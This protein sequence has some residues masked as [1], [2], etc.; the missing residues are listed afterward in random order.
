MKFIP[1]SKWIPNLKRPLV[2]AGP[3]SAESEEQVVGLAHRLREIEDVRIYRAGIWKPRTRPNAFEGHGEKALPW[4]ARVKKE[5]GLLTA[6][7]VANAQHAE[8]AL[9][10]GID[11][12]WIGARTTVSPF[13]VQEIADATRGSNAIVMI[14]NPVSADL[15]LWIGAFERFSQ[16]GIT[17]LAAIHRGFTTGSESK[18]RNPPLW[19]LPVALKQRFPDLPMICDPSHITGNRDLV[20]R[21]CQK[22]MDVDMDGLMIETHFT[23]DEAWSDAAQQV[24]PDQLASII[25]NLELRTEFSLDRGFEQELDGLRSQIDRIDRDIIEA[26]SLRMN[27]VEKIAQSK[28]KNNITAFQLH[29]MDQMMKN[30]MALGEKLGLEQNYINELYG[31]IHGES[32]KL[33]TSLMANHKK[34]S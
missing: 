19:A 13:A 5:T 6:C 3:C 31:V 34:D 16:A 24:T 25:Q 7:E 27:V 11:I 8:L 29:R 1:L 22:A 23:P 14:K 12:L 28:I 21:I 30:R 2:I 26:L 17:K 18:Y 33:Q 10:H 20:G 4:L 32:V 9:K 15:N